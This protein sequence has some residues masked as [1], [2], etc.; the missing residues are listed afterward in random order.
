MWESA[1]FLL[2][3]ELC[4]SDTSALHWPPLFSSDSSGVICRVDGRLARLL[5]DCWS[6]CRVVAAWIGIGEGGS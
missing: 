4:Q 3:V 1:T 2:L 5:F 6:V